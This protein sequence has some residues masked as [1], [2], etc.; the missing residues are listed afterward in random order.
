M[1]KLLHFDV[2]ERLL[3]DQQAVGFANLGAHLLPRVIS[4]GGAHYDLE[5]RIYLPDARNGFNPIP[6][7]RHA[8][9]HEGEGV[10]PVLRQ[11]LLNHL[12]PLLALVSGVQLKNH[13]IRLVLIEQHRFHLVCRGLVRIVRTEDIPEVS[14]DAR[15]VVN[16][17]DA[18][19]W[20]KVGAFHDFSCV[21]G[22]ASG[23]A[24]AATGNSR[25]N[26]APLPGPSL[27]AVRVPPI[28]FAALAPLW[29]P[30]PCPSF[31]VVKPWLK[32]PVRCSGAIPMP[33]SAMVIFTRSGDAIP[34]RTTR[35]LACPL[36]ASM[37]YLALR[38]R[39]MRICNTLCRSTCT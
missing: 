11:R 34:T 7:G 10:R 33:L 16:D 38:R 8:H 5:F 36:C 25:I 39:L 20:S 9:V 32:I 29:R 37:A 26:S 30:K 35:R 22:C 14:M 12:E 28:S 27:R 31:L 17:Q 24:G 18:T 15:V 6:T 13:L 2:V 21:S 23:R 4:V 1:G 3:E 19:V